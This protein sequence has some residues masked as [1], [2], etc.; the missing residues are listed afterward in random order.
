MRIPLDSAFCVPIGHRC[1][2][3]VLVL[4]NLGSK[5]GDPSQPTYSGIV[6]Q[7]RDGNLY[8]T[9]PGGGAKSGGAVFKVT[10]AGTLSVL[11][12]FTGGGSDGFAPMGG[13]TLGTDGNFYGTTFEGGESNLGTVFKITSTGR[14]TT[15]YTF[16]GIGDGS[17]PQAPPIQG[18]DGNFYGTTTGGTV[19]ELTPSGNLTTLYTFDTGGSPTTPLVEGTDGN[20]YG[21]TSDWCTR[22]LPL[23]SLLSC[24]RFPY[25]MAGNL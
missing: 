9:A 2:C 4:Y 19:Y 1:P 23:G 12:S 13:L 7:G 6:A 16:T 24:I 20:F 8:S 3:S 15:L 17:T 22:S 14:L 25:Q 18:T 21:T 10:P 11:Y 5:R